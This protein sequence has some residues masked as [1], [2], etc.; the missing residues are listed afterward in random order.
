MM[1][2]KGWRDGS[3]VKS[4]SCSSRG[5]QFNSQHPQGSSKLSNTPFLGDQTPSSG[6]HTGTRY[7]HGSSGPSLRAHS[8]TWKARGRHSQRHSAL[9]VQ[10]SVEA[11]GQRKRRREQSAWLAAGRA[12]G[13]REIRPRIRAGTGSEG[14][15]DRLQRDWE[16]AARLSLW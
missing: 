1:P 12:A 11:C 4:T 7:R 8:V 6:L 3:V 10:P 14:R 13:K 9:W 16:A 15:Q 2:W 5:L